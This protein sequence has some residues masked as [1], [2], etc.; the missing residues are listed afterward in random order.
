MLR[1]GRRRRPK[2]G[3]GWSSF[4]YTLHLN[5]YTVCSALKTPY[6]YTMFMKSLH[7]ILV[8]HATSDDKGK[9]CTQNEQNVRTIHCTT[10]KSLGGQ[11]HATSHATSSRGASVRFTTTSRAGFGSVGRVGLLLACVVLACE[12]LASVVL[13]TVVLVSVV[14][15]TV[16]LVSVVPVGRWRAVG[17]VNFGTR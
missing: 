8:T 14:L 12:V 4:A 7:N 17:L 6:I 13:A 11:L 16:V 9:E 15:A 3:L 5:L 2:D 10:C 1:V